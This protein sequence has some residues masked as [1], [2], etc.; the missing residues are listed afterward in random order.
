[1][2]VTT[3]SIGMLLATLSDPAELDD[4]NSLTCRITPA[5]RRAA[6]DLWQYELIAS[7]YPTD[8]S[9][10]FAAQIRLPTVDLHEVINRLRRR[11]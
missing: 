8:K 7:R 4:L 11:H 9:I 3:S 1:M 2:A 6:P 5:E 10:V